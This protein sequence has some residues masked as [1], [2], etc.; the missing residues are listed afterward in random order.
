MLKVVFSNDVWES[1]EDFIRAIR[2]YGFIC[3]ELNLLNSN[4]K[5]SCSFLLLVILW[6]Q[7]NREQLYEIRIY[8]TKVNILTIDLT[9]LNSKTIT[10]FEFRGFSNKIDSFYRF[11]CFHPNRNQYFKFQLFIGPNNIFFIAKNRK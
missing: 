9:V 6:I 11:Y 10:Y 4:T 3:L 2:F 7:I 1:K 5:I 8:G